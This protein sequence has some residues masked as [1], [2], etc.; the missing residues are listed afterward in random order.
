MKKRKNTKNTK[1]IWD[2]AYWEIQREER[3]AW[4]SKNAAWHP[5][6]GWIEVYPGCADTAKCGE[7]WFQ[8][9]E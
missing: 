1:T 5:E 6:I 8:P 9:G 3:M 7:G 2:A 4:L